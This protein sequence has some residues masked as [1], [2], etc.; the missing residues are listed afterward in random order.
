VLYF[1]H[2]YRSH[3]EYIR[4]SRLFLWRKTVMNLKKRGRR[5]MKEAIQQVVLPGFTRII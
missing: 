1:S 5:K 3:Y 2:T 4:P